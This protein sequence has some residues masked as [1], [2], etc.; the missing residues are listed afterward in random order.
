MFIR[1]GFFARPLANGNSKKRSLAMTISK[2]AL[3]FGA[4]ALAAAVLP[5]AASAAPGVGLGTQVKPANDVVKV[6]WRHRHHYDDNDDA[7]VHAPLTDVQTRR[8]G[9]RVWAPFA[10][11]DTTGG[12]V[13][14]HAPFV[15][16]NRPKDYD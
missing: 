1:S 4:A 15:N 14:V 11:V 16:I 10:F 6:G 5:G 8:S 9:S 7:D 13:R 2:F 3:A 12:R